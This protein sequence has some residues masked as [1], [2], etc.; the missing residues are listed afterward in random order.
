MLKEAG[1]T[2]GEIADVL[3]QSSVAMARHYSSEAE[4]PAKSR[5]IVLEL[6]W[7]GRKTGTA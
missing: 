5:E 2:D 7:S 4:L 3:G 1:L 6:D